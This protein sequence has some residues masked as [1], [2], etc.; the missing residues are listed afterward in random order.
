M[1]KNQ[2]AAADG[3]TTAPQKEAA[4]PLQLHCKVLV[5]GMLYA[6]AH[7]AKGKLLSIPRDKAE[8]LAG[9]KPPHV[10]ILGVK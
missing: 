2:D 3:Q 6:D 5:N 9:M 7:H 10:E 4:Q 1:N 8:F